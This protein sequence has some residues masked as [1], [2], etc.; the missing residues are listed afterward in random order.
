MPV[1]QVMDVQVSV[2][3]NH[4]AIHN[5]VVVVAHIN[6]RLVCM[7][8]INFN[9]KFRTMEHPPM[10]AVRTIVVPGARVLLMPTV[11]LMDIRH[12]AVVAVPAH[13]APV[14]RLA[15]ATVIA[16]AHIQHAPVIVV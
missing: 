6:V 3:A 1:R 2:I 10:V 11:M 12:A 14:A 5:A 16:Q 13:N 9:A 8:P 15:Q 4:M 7:V